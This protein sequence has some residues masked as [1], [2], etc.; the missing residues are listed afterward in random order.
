LQVGGE[1]LAVIAAEP[2]CV[3]ETLQVVPA[4][5]PLAPP[6]ERAAGEDE[7]QVRGGFG[8]THP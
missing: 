6:A 3:A 5:H 4:A 7:I 8:T 2:V 1:Q